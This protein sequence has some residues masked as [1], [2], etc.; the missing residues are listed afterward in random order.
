MAAILKRNT[1]FN[2]FFADNHSL[3]YSINGAI[4]IWE[5]HWENGFRK[6]VV[7]TPPPLRHQRV[8]NTLDT[9]VLM[10]QN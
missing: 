6:G 4:F 3:T 1:F 8:G 9:S 10:I 2:F 7:G 5:Y